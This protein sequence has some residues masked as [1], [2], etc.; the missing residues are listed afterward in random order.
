ML[1][2]IW[3]AVED[4]YLTIIMYLLCSIPMRF[5]GKTSQMIHNDKSQ[6]EVIGVATIVEP[7]IAGV[8]GV[9]RGEMLSRLAEVLALFGQASLEAVFS[10]VHSLLIHWV[11]SSFLPS[12]VA[13]NEH[14]FDILIQF[15]EQDIG[16]NG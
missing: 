9:F 4:E 13:G 16:K 7:P 2:I 6:S 12:G 15:I 1:D 8:L 10:L 11:F 5:S 3:N 14:G